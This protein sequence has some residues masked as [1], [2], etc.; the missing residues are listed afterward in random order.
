M[1]FLAQMGQ[2]NKCGSVRNDKIFNLLSGSGAGTCVSIPCQHPLSCRSKTPVTLI[3]S[4]QTINNK[5][6]PKNPE[7]KFTIPFFNL[8]KGVH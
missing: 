2:S 6:K 5:K 4:N 1:E 8:E 7:M 3:S